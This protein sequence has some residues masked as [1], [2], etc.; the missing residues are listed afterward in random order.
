MALEVALVSIYQ[1]VFRCLSLRKIHGR[2]KETS[3]RKKVTMNDRLPVPNT[4]NIF[5]RIKRINSAGVEFWSARELARVLEYLNFRNFQPVI[6]KAKEACINSGH[7]VADHIA[8]MSNMVDIG[9][10]AQ[11][12]LE[13]LALSRYACYLIIQNADPGKPLVALGQS[14]FAVQTRRQEMADA[15]ALK[16]DKTR[17]LL[18]AE[19]KK[20]NKT[21][22]STCVMG[23]IGLEGFCMGC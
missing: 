17:L 23:K 5:E 15:E 19:M 20:H 4:N 2:R 21:A 12:D 16:E 10:G 18:L 7:A 14:Y 22:S 1:D 6:E 13:D 9:S 11:R 3:R 8:E